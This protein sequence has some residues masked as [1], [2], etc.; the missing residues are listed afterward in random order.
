MQIQKQKVESIIERIIENKTYNK[1][2]NSKVSLK[3]NNVKNEIKYPFIE[4]MSYKLKR[5]GKRGTAYLNILEEEVNKTGISVEEAIRKEHFDIALQ[6][7][8]IGNSITS[9]KEISRINFLMLL[10]EINGVEEI[11]KKDPAQVYSKM[12]FR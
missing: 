8:L 3:S 5:F 7:V 1:F 12:D 9:I 6:K 2:K 10:E 4:Y 11:L